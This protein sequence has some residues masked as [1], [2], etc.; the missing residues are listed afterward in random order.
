MRA[1]F[2]PAH[3]I[4]GQ[5]LRRRPNNTLHPTPLPSQTFVP[6]FKGLLVG[7]AAGERGR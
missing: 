1:S 4:H 7:K 2:N 3:E 6:I 5:G